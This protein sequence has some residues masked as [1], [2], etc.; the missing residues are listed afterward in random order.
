MINRAA[1]IVRLK[2]PFIQWINDADPLD[3]RSAITFEEANEDRT[4]YL[5]DESEADH[6]E[7]WLALN[8]MQVFECELEDWY[9][10]PALWPKNITMELFNEWCDIDCHTVIVDTVGGPIVDD[11]GEED[12]VEE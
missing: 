11:E 1:L 12:F 6:V 4:V 3:N 5:I 7:E 10:D 9:A 8:F 2:E